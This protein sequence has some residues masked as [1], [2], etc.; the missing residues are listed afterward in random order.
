MPS[1]NSHFVQPLYKLSTSHFIISIHNEI[2]KKPSYRWKRWIDLYTLS[3]AM[4][5]LFLIYSNE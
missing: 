4:N 3:Y 1:F 2:N 5:S